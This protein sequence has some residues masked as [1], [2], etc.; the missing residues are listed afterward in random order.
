MQYDRYQIV[1][2]GD[3]WAVL[4]NASTSRTFTKRRDA[5]KGAIEAVLL[6]G[7]EGIAAEVI[8]QGRGGKP[9]P[10]WTIGRDT[11]SEGL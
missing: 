4:L 9:V 2:A 1:H 8:A 6:A 3:C 5:I 7:E 11:C 10:L